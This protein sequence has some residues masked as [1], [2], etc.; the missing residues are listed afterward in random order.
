[1]A[2]IGLA[3]ALRNVSEGESYCPYAILKLP[4]DLEDTSALDAAM[5][6]GVPSYLLAKILRTE[7][8]KISHDSIQDHRDQ[9]CKCPEEIK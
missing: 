8:Y 5:T 9:I 6:K 4:L 3:A 1:M 7:G 2:K